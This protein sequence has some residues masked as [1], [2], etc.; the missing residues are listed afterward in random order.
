M[1]KQIAKL[2]FSLAVAWAVPILA[3]QGPV[4]TLTSRIPLAN[5]QGRMDHVGVD[6]QGQ[7]LFATA[8][9]NRTVEVVDLRADKQV[10]TIADVNR[11]QAAFYDPSSNRLFVSCGGDGS[12]KIFDGKTFQLLDTVKLSSD[13]DNIRYDSRRRQVLVGYGGEKLLMGKVIRGQGDGALAML[14]DSGKKTGEIAVDAHPES[15]Q[16]EKNGTRVFINVPD[17]HEIQVADLDKKQVLA[18]WPVRCT[19]SFPMTLDEGHHRLFVGCRQPA[20][21]E[22]FDTQSG[23]VVTSLPAPASD[24]IFYDAAKGRIYVLGNPGDAKEAAP[25]FMDVFQQ[26]D[27][28]HYAKIASYP[29]G[30]GAWTGFFVPEWGKLF[31]S[32]RRQG[33]QSAQI[34]VY[35]TK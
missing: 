20:S 26:K 9:D 25:G 15:F 7:R 31:V 22:V 29:T 2:L 24:D 16:L 18:H 32:V 13:A 8:I 33:E 11:P 12:V 10:H 35:E 34:L 21:L 6:V 30:S 19:D 1:E 17:R 3:Q 23:K 27:P 28:D 5:V 14:D 4:L